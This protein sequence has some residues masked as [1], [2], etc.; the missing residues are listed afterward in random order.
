MSDPQYNNEQTR[1]SNQRESRQRICQDYLHRRIKAFLVQFAW[2]PLDQFDQ[3]LGRHQNR[4]HTFELAGKKKVKQLKKDMTCNNPFSI[5]LP[6]CRNKWLA[7]CRENPLHGKK[8][9]CLEFVRQEI[10]HGRATMDYSV[11]RFCSKKADDPLC[12]CVSLPIGVANGANDVSATY[13]PIPCWYKEC[14]ADR[15][16]TYDLYKST[17]TEKC[18]T[19]RCILG[20]HDF[21]QD[22]QKLY[23]LP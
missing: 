23:L 9:Q 14:T 21:E 19:P 11:K 13:G 10:I 1:Q 18:P 2:I 17:I 7:E 12:S 4:E 16:L 20:T 5:S 22:H 6:E 8:G 15:L 3:T